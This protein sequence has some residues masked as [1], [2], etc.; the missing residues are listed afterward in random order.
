MHKALFAYGSSN[1]RV[2]TLLSALQFHGTVWQKRVQRRLQRTDRPEEVQRGRG[3]RF[4]GSAA[5]SLRCAL[6]VRRVATSHDSAVDRHVAGHGGWRRFEYEIRRPL[7]RGAVPAP[8]HRLSTNAGVSREFSRGFGRVSSA[9]CEPRKSQPSRLYVFDKQG[10][11][12]VAS[13]TDFPAFPLTH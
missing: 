4:H 5:A 11:A 8:C 6:L 2:L 9:L 13:V 10:L 1:V 12:R 3:V 7:L